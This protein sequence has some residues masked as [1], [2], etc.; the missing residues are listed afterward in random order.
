LSSHQLLKNVKIKTYK[1]IVLLVVLYG[2]ETWSVTLVKKTDGKVFDNR[3]SKRISGLKRE[4]VT[5]GLRKLH[6]EA[7]HNFT[8][9]PDI[10]RIMK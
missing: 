10:I 6:H 4:E 3:V 5:K 1:T 8:S 2:R 9:L 7:L